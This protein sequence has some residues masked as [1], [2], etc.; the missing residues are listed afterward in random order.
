MERSS[1]LLPGT[2]GHTRSGDKT[3][4]HER[5]PIPTRTRNPQVGI[6]A[7]QRL[8][9]RLTTQV[10]IHGSGVR[11][12]VANTTSTVVEHRSSRNRK[13]PQTRTGRCRNFW[14]DLCSKSSTS[15]RKTRWVVNVARRACSCSRF[16]IQ[17]LAPDVGLEPTTLRL[18]A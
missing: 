5:D 4:D 17:H 18:R 10:V 16:Y 9:S 15:S 8:G 3:Q 7:D 12:K 14:E 11:R 2:E 13:P 6:R 1:Q